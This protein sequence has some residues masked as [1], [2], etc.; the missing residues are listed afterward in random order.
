MKERSREVVAFRAET[1]A[2]DLRYAL[3][4]LKAN[5]GFTIVILLTLALAIGANTA[6]F[7]VINGVLLKRLP[8]EQPDRLVRIFLSN[9]TYPKFEL[10]PFD[11]LDFRARNRSFESMAAFTRG[12]VQLS[13]DGEPVR[14]YGFGITSGYFHVLGLHPQLGREFDR[15]M[16]AGIP[17]DHAAGHDETAIG[18]HAVGVALRRR[19][20]ARLQYLRP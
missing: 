18:R 20:T 15:Q 1:V 4:Q 11:F 9:A 13:G 19:P 12:D 7:S 5:P 8:F 16:A 10:N 3:R 2:H 6:I 14:L 17:P